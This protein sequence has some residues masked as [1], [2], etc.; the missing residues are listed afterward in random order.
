MFLIEGEL[1][2]IFHVD[3]YWSTS[4]IIWRQS[5]NPLCKFLPVSLVNLRKGVE[6][7]KIS[8]I[9]T[10]ANTI[11][12]DGFIYKRNEKNMENIPL[13]TESF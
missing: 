11:W 13:F 6:G 5:W 1:S 2:R 7:Y 4:E 12:Y 9:E 8:A 3:E 10:I